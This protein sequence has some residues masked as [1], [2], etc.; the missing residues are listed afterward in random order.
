[1]D[2]DT[3]TGGLLGYDDD[4][5][6]DCDV[7]DRELHTLAQE[8]N[9]H[10]KESDCFG[11]AYLPLT[12]R[13]AYAPSMSQL[14]RASSMHAM[15]S[16]HMASSGKKPAKKTADGKQARAESNSGSLL[17]DCLP[18]YGLFEAS[19]IACPVL[20]QYHPQQLME[21][22]SSGMDDSAGVY[23][24]VS[25]IDDGFP[26]LQAKFAGLRQSW[27]IWYVVFREVVP[28]IVMLRRRNR[29]TKQMTS[30]RTRVG[31]AP[32]PCPL[33]APVKS[34]TSARRQWQPF[35]RSLL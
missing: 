28:E 35:L 31:P 21:L 2:S 4:V 26:C 16:T 27:L 25:E 23:R 1:M 32:E 24:T 3:E 8:G 11:F 14:P 10:W 6:E 7:L 33:V 34:S 20:P 9:S 13:V 18:S 12:G 5:G 15:A 19:Q 22:L 17:H 30:I 29:M